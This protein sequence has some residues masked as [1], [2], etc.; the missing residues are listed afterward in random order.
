MAYKL[1]HSIV[2]PSNIV[3]RQI[4]SHQPGL[5]RKIHLVP[6]GVDVTLFQS[7]STRNSFKDMKRAGR[8]TILYLGRLYREKHIELAIDALAHALLTAPVALIIAGSGPDAEYYREYAKTKAVLDHVVFIGQVEQPQEILATVDI[9]IQPSPRESYGNVLLEAMAAGVPV[10]AWRPKWPEC[11]VASDEIVIDGLT[12]FL[13]DPFDTNA[14]AARI[15]QLACDAPL[16][17]KMKD[18]AQRLVASHDIGSMVAHYLEL[19]TRNK[20][21]N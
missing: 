4:L 3:K 15:T 20:D 2:V 16:R 10:I 11:Q 12:G 17:A 8:T 18:A 1:S 5:A 21:A 6:H 7:Q 13:I 19:L 9:L 14:M